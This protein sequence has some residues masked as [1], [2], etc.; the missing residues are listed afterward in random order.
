MTVMHLEESQVQRLLHGELA[1]AETFPVGEHMAQCDDCRS[2]VNNARRDEDEVHDLLRHL[3]HAPPR[4]EAHAL[5]SSAQ[6]RSPRWMSRAAAILLILSVGGVA[7]AAPR[8]PLRAWW[9]SVIGWIDGSAVSPTPIVVPL[10]EPAFAGIAVDPGSS[11]VIRFTSVQTEGDARV[12]LTDGTD[13]VVRA[14]V[15][16]STFTSNDDAL[17]IDNARSRASFEVE[18]PRTAAHVEIRV[19]GYRV[20]L[21]RG[22]RIS[23]PGAVHTEGRY[24]I[25]LLV[26]RATSRGMTQRP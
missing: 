22:A 26:E 1:P 9:G 17:V 3:D 18:I 10:P 23:A 19:N 8:S 16:S 13:V 25:P 15:G 20:F 14:P 7:W 5:I 21:K 24:V 11:L 12:S 4:V 6:F 2:R